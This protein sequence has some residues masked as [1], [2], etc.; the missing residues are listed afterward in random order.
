MSLPDSSFGIFSC[1]INIHGQTPSQAGYLFNAWTA[2]FSE[3][4]G[5]FIYN[6]DFYVGNGFVQLSLNTTG[7]NLMSGQGWHHLL[8]AWDMTGVSFG[9]SL[10]IDDIAT[11]FSVSQYAQVSIPWS[12]FDQANM[13][14]YIIGGTSLFNGCFGQCYVNTQEFLDF[15]I[16]S[17]RR[18]FITATIGRVDLGT[19]GELPTGTSPSFYLTGGASD[20]TMNKGNFVVT[21]NVVGTFIDCTD[22]AP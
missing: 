21:D 3:I 19:N 13:L 14:S 20:I 9:G 10:Y 8:F 6:G 2:G 12:Q 1:W 15:T 11:S 16:V 4:L 7:S 17:N 22:P 18:K 5:F